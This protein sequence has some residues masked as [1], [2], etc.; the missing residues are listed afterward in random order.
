[1]SFN[2]DGLSAILWLQFAVAAYVLFWPALVRGWNAVFFRLIKPLIPQP[3]SKPI[4]ASAERHFRGKFRE[5]QYQ[6]ADSNAGQR[7]QATPPPPP[8]P[9]SERATCLGILGL[10]DPANRSEI[11]LA[12]RRLAKRYHPDGYAPSA[13]ARKDAANR[14]RQINYAYDWLSA[15]G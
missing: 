1:M 2:L 9:P 7:Q 3:V 15:D 8:K 4:A 10:T 6:R 12:Y 13:Q 14:M 5:A 11:K